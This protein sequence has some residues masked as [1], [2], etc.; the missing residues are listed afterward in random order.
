MRSANA[1][2]AGDS[3]LG[4]LVWML[5]GGAAPAEALPYAVAA[6]SA[7][8]LS[9]GTGLCDGPHVE[10]LAKGIVVERL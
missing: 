2:G 6:G 7:A 5:A 8:M 1:V 9:S 3:F 10:Q 4:A